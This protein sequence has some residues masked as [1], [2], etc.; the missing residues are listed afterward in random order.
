MDRVG[1]KEFAVLPSVEQVFLIVLLVAQGIGFLDAPS[2]RRVVAGNGQPNGTAVLEGHLLLHETFAEG[3]P[4]DDGGAVVILHGAGEDLGGR[5][6]EII[7][8]HD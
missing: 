2:G 3:A 8:E 6:G 7:N 5:G 4:T 1:G